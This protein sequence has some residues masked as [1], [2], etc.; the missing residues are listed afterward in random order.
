MKDRQTLFE[1]I[2]Y[3][4]KEY[5]TK[6]ADTLDE[7]QNCIILGNVNWL[8]LN[9]IEGED[10]Q[11]DK[12]AKHFNLH[13]LIIEDIKLLEH[14]PK[15]DEFE[16]IYFSTLRMIRWNK[17]EKKIENEQI[18]IVFGNDYL[19]TFQEDFHND[20]NSIIEK[21]TKDIGKIRKKS[22]DYLFYRILDCI[23]DSY[24]SV[25]EIV[26]EKIE[27]LEDELMEASSK[28]HIKK[29][30]GAKKH[31]D[32]VR[33]TIIPLSEVLNTSKI[34]EFDIIDE[35]NYMFFSDIRDHINHLISNYESNREILASLIDLNI[36]NINN[37]TNSVMKSLTIIAS[38]FIPLTFIVGV[39]GM[40]FK[41][42][43][44]LGWKYGY[45]IVWSIMITIT[46]FLIVYMKKK[47][48]F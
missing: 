13:P 48:W 44:E 23:V 47:K 28:D 6:N 17:E 26:N 35:Q 34:I 24:Y 46:I 38:I 8:N 36:S 25:L 41:N 15:I 31:L 39:Y 21:I 43:P 4:S 27:D 33:K 10:Q 42:L 20:F 37:S 12:L 45:F 30:H 7:F 29:I 18:S 14:L 1:Y 2:S 40:N 5:I 11:I 9:W 3:N 22:V 32:I 16:G 19:I